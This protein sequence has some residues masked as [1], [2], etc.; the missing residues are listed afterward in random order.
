MF[1]SRFFVESKIAIELKP[2]YSFEW[3]ELVDRLHFMENR[4]KT[5]NEIIRLEGT[6]WDAPSNKVIVATPN[7]HDE[8]EVSSLLYVWI[9]HSNSCQLT[10]VVMLLQRNPLLGAYHKR[11]DPA[12]PQL[13]ELFALNSVKEEAEKTFIVLSDSPQSAR[14]DAPEVI[15][16]IIDGAE[17]NSKNPFSL[18]RRKLMF[19]E[20]GP[21]DLESTN[22][23]EVRYYVPDA[24]GKSH[25]RVEKK[26]PRILSREFPPNSPNLAYSCASSSPLAMPRMLHKPNI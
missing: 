23:K 14:H 15:A 24:K 13:Y 26:G 10:Y 25:A 8:L 17:V 16:P 22:K 1:P 3:F 5:F 18:S 20:G 7:W 19:D 2:G 6:Y 9:F 21:L 11:G 4:Y 12:Y